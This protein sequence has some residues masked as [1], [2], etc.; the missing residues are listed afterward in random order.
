[1]RILVLDD[2]ENRLIQFKINLAGH[3]VVCVKTAAEA[4]QQ[5]DQNNFNIAFLD[6]DLGGRVLVPSGPGTG[7]EVAQWIAAHENKQPDKIF[8]H[9]FNEPAAKRMKSLLPNA[10][11]APGVWTKLDGGLA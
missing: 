1:M 9:S 3:I 5:L 4:I 11:I 8:I 2:E 7:Y 10:V 6:H